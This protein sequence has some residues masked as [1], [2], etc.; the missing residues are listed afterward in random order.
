MMNECFNKTKPESLF[1]LG[2]IGAGYVGLPM[3]AGFASQGYEVSVAERDQSRFTM[4]SNAI[5]PI[6]EPGLDELLTAGI[7]SGKL[8]FFKSS[9]EAALNA[10]IIFLCVATPSTPEGLADLSYV[11]AAAI[12]I[13]PVLKS[14][15][16]VV[17]KSTVPVGTAEQVRELL[18]RDDIFVVSNP[19]F[20]SEG[21]AVKESYHPERIVIGSDNLE[22]GNKV[23]SLFSIS[24]APIIHT[25]N[26]TAELIKYTA[27]AFLA[28]KL[29]FI[30]AIAGLC[31]ETG[32]DVTDLV[33]AVGLDS[34]IGSKF[35]SPGPGWGGS[36][37]PK[38]TLALAALADEYNYSFPLL[39]EVVATNLEQ[40]DRIV[41]KVSR[42]ADT[43]PNST[44]AVWGLTFKAGTNDRRNSPSLK[45]INRLMA[46]GANVVAY[47]PSVSVGDP[48]SDL[49]GI[50]LCDNKYDATKEADVLVILTE[51]PEFVS[52]D[53][54]LLK[55]SMYSR[56]IV[57]A[58]NM[59]DI[60][61]SIDAG[62][63]YEGIGNSAVS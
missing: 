56:V 13:A 7:E 52:P 16:I 54:E 44:I 60:K 58:R 12:E 53:F 15:A 17:N 49:D 33:K 4:L 62:F 10:D 5:S 35:L 19:E 27:N 32:A 46:L 18:N 9:M 50:S 45:I 1:K 51:W 30:N 8:R 59:L 23:A 36:C 31:E 55:N 41:N 28:T 61:E 48:G 37:F 38:D 11:E 6:A 34:R 20:F 42:A 47:D 3:A 40:Y 21:N 22:A 39:G 29:S 14:G 57:D 26:R 25:D 24:G 2:I 63:T 43:L